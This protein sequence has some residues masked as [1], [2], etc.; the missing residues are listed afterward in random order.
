MPRSHGAQRPIAVCKG[1]SGCHGTSAAAESQ[2]LIKAIDLAGKDR[3]KTTP[4][5]TRARRRSRTQ[6]SRGGLQVGYGDKVRH[7]PGR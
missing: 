5:C 2:R 3:I 1:K 6:M 7:Y 4:Y